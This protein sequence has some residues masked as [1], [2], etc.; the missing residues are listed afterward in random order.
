MES[1]TKMPKETY[2]SPEEVQQIID[3]LR[4]IY[5][6]N[7]ISRNNKFIREYTKPTF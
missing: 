3:N 1:E 5:Y 6:N 2:I 7:G 4:L